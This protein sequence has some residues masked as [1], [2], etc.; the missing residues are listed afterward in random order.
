MNKIKEII[1]KNKKLIIISIISIILVNLFS[2]TYYIISLFNKTDPILYYPKDMVIKN[3]IKPTLNMDNVSNNNINEYIIENINQEINLIEIFFNSIPTDM[4]VSYTSDDFK[5]FKHINQSYKKEG[6]INQK[7]YIISTT[8]GKIKDLKIEISNGDLYNI[9]INPEVTY[10]KNIGLNIIVLGLVLSIYYIT[11]KNDKLNLKSY[12]QKY[13]MFLIFTALISICFAFYKS[14]QNQL[15]LH[16]I[17]GNMYDKYYVDAVMNGKL[18]LDIPVDNK[19]LESVN[20]YDTSNRNFSYVWDASFYK[21]KYY[22]YFSIWPILTLFIPYKLITKNYL[23][24]SLA[25]LIYSTLAIIGT[26][27]IF[28]K[29]IEKY[30]KNISIQTYIVSFL[31]IILGSKLLWCMHRPSFY[32]LTSIAAYAHVVFGLYLV[33]FNNHKLKNFIGYTL[34]ALAVL[35]RP[36]T[37]FCS[38]LILPKIFNQIKN[39]QFKFID[40]ILLAIPYILVGAFTMYLNYIR[41]GS[42]FEFGISY[43]LTTNNLSN[44]KF[45]FINCIYGIYNYLF[46]RIN[47]S[48][49]PFH[50]SGEMTTLPILG[51]FNIEQAGGGII[52]TS[53]LGIILLFIPQIFK[54]IKEK[55]LKIYIIITIVVGFLLMG[56]SSG[57]GAIIG[58]YML[59]FNYLFYFIIVILSLTIINKFKNKAILK[60]YHIVAIISILLN[61]FL[62]TNI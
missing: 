60:I 6:N 36:S 28:K 31:Y 47:I 35:C 33:L 29:I 41:F 57:I 58:R 18:D 38:I 3:N 39:K 24:T 13:I 61:L 50:L 55:E 45:S 8:N 37:L 42:I 51:D 26:Y 15:E 53:I 43:Q 52:P 48:I 32:E 40:F 19:L 25:T 30:F 20:P 1:K 16:I 44:Y 23:P 9:T 5:N 7:S 11:Q 4:K 12:K 14:Y 17:R 59:D 2:N 27:L 54:Y 49:M 62:S 22:C 21:G 56:F 10:N 34:L 46:N